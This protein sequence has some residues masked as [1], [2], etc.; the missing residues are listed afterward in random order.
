MAHPYGHH[1]TNTGTLLRGA[2]VVLVAVLLLL[3]GAPTQEAG[4]QNGD[5]PTVERVSPALEIVSVKLG[6]TQEFTAQVNSTLKDIIVYTATVNGWSEQTL[7]DQPVQNYEASFRH[8]FDEAGNFTVGIRFTGVETRITATWQVT[9]TNSAPTITSKATSTSPDGAFILQAG[10]GLSLSAVAGDEDGNLVSATWLIDGEGTE[11]PDDTFDNVS[12]ALSS[13]T[14]I[15]SEAGE[16]EVTVKFSDSEG[17]SVTHSWTVRVQEKVPENNRPPS[18]VPVSPTKHL[19]L[20]I[21]Q[22]QTF[23]ASASDPDNNISLVEWLIDGEVVESTPLDLTGSVERSYLPTF[24]DSGYFRIEARFSDNGKLSA[25]VLFEVSVGNWPVIDSLGCQPESPTV[26]ETITCQPVLTGG[27]PTGYVWGA[28]D[29]PESVASGNDP[30]FSV[31][32]DSPGEKRIVFGVVTDIGSDDDG[33]TIFV[34]ARSASAPS[35]DGL[36]CSP[37][38]P[39]V[40]DTVTCSPSLSGGAVSTYAWNAPGGIPSTGSDATFATTWNSAGDK[41]VSLEACNNDGCHSA[42]QTVT[43]SDS[44]T[45]TVTTT[46]T[47][48][49]EEVT[50]VTPTTT[51]SVPPAVTALSLQTPEELDGLEAGSTYEFTARAT[52]ANADIVLSLWRII[53]KFGVISSTSRFGPS[54]SVESTLSY[55]VPAAGNYLVRVDFDDSDGWTGFTEWTFSAIDPPPKVDALSCTLTSPQVGETVSCSAT[56]SGSSP[57]IDLWLAYGSESVRRDGQDYVASWDTPGDKQ[58]AL[59]VCNRSGDCDSLTQPIQVLPEISPPTID[60]LG[61]DQEV[62]HVGENLN[63]SPQIS[64]GPPVKFLWTAIDGFPGTGESETFA[65]DWDVR[66]DKTVTLKVCNTIDEC[67]TSSQ[68]ITV[69]HPIPPPVID[70]LGCEPLTV[71]VDED[72]ECEARLVENDQ[73]VFYDRSEDDL[74]Y[75]WS[76]SSSDDYKYEWEGQDLSVRWFKSGKEGI[77]LRVCNIENE[78]DT[79][80]QRITVRLDPRSFLQI[81]SLGCPIGEVEVGQVVTC[82]PDVDSDRQVDYDWTAYSGSPRN[83]SSRR[84]QTRWSSPGTKTIELEVCDSR[85]CVEAERRVEVVDPPPTNRPPVVTRVSPGSPV[86]VLVGEN[87]TFVAQATDTDLRSYGW[88]VTQRSTP[89]TPPLNS[90]SSPTQTYS[91]VFDSPGHYLVSVAFYDSAGQSGVTLWEVTAVENPS[92]PLTDLQA[93]NE[94]FLALQDIKR[95]WLACVDEHPDNETLCLSEIESISSAGIA[96]ANLSSIFDQYREEGLGDEFIEN[97]ATILRAADLAQDEVR[98]ASLRILQG[99]LCGQACLELEVDGSESP[100]YL[101]GWLLAG[102]VPVVDIVTD[103]R[104]FVVSGVGCIAGLLSLDGCDW[105]D[106]GVNGLGLAT[107]FVPLGVGQAGNVAQ[108][109]HHITKFAGEIGA[110]SHQAY[111]TC[112]ESRVKNS[113]VGETY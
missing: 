109:A 87:Y 19:S 74:F 93:I 37:T 89:A 58:V 16:Y 106:L 97:V 7:L 107:S 75:S 39:G 90:G 73:E 102:F 4:A 47:Q 2:L 52:D 59:V 44:E 29:G 12:S 98:E 92:I 65:P 104:D 1:S 66:G 77:K 76:L 84:F 26:G 111:S 91:H 33:V 108:A 71:D 88:Q 18:A 28:S 24:P 45:P 63:C 105:V 49:P 5:E 34:T 43:V 46:T 72:V 17:D 40:G 103:G 20:D 60:S 27:T 81:N 110:E 69:G 13:F 68:T 48:P 96:T 35:I 70:T 99:A 9:V 95:Q 50:G 54:S 64:G 22:S 51:V 30:T 36:N 67:D 78:C 100:W 62:V 42:D 61:C 113:L 57:E 85:D 53:N 94:S 56:L 31:Q 86:T 55:L 6:D 32:F 3:L 83:G 112:P 80:R 11:A 38:N 82:N 14:H 79:E 21:G 15:Y 41:S 101:V 25:A 23:T 10:S 8:T